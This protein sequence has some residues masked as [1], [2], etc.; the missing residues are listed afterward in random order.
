[1]SLGANKARL[2]EMTKELLCRWQETRAQWRDAKGAEF[3]VRYM[4]ELKSDVDQAMTAMDE[5]EKV[6]LK[7]K[8]DCE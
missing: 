5:L 7:M 4:R 3:E 6:L 1:M 2:G 8:K